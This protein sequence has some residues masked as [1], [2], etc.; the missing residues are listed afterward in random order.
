MRD[1]V[2]KLIAWYSDS[3]QAGGYPLVIL[4]MAIESSVIPVPSELVIPP[5]AYL[6]YSQGHMSVV[7]VILAGALGSWFGATAM[8]WVSRIAGRPLA[9]KYGSYFLIFPEKIESAERW[10]ARYGGFGV[11]ASRL[12]PVIR[13]LIGI[14]SGIVRLNFVTYSLYTLLGSLIWCAV[15]S[16]V[17][18]VAGNDAALM[19]GDLHSITI[20]LV[21]A[22]VVLGGLYYFLVHRQ[23]RRAS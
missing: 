14:P 7:G 6:A 3:L 4:L 10:S 15:L 12:L 1:L 2:A 5:A 13:H 23:M 11:F 9:I 17:G 20:W 22:V 19:K 8:Y 18:V 16:W 21:G